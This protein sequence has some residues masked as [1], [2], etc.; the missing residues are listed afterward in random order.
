VPDRTDNPQ[1]RPALQVDE[2]ATVRPASP[3]LTRP[4]W[5]IPPK[6]KTKDS[7]PKGDK[8]VELVVPMTKNLR[9]EIRDKAEQLGYTPEEAAF[10]VLRTW[11]D[12]GH[13]DGH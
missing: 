5:V 13:S 2:D 10:H 4:A 9:R 11:V 12:N 6:S 1:P 8:A 7:P 3:R